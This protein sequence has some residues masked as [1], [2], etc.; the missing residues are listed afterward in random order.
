MKKLLEWVSKAMIVMGIDA[1]SL[2]NMNKTLKWSGILII[3]FIILAAIFEPPKSLEQ[4][5]A[6]ATAREQQSAKQSIERKAQTR[7]LSKTIASVFGWVSVVS[8]ALAAIIEPKEP[9]R[10]GRF[11]TGYKNNATVRKKSPNE[12]RT[13]ISAITIGS[14]A[15]II[16]HFLR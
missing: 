15:S 9:K 3:C 4:K 5:L 10:D 2:R 14:V 16:W 6:E 12:I 11:K 1:A 7:E 13:Q 8:F